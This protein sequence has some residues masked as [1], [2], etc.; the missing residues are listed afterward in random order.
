MKEKDGP[1][2]IQGRYA[3]NRRHEGKR[4]SLEGVAIT[5]WLLGSSP[6]PSGTLKF[7]KIEIPPSTATEFLQVLV[8]GKKVTSDVTTPKYAIKFGRVPSVQHYE[9]EKYFLDNETKG[10][11]QNP[12][13]QNYQN[14][15]VSITLF[16]MGDEVAKIVV[17]QGPVQDLLIVISSWL[18][19]P[20]G[21]L[22]TGLSGHC[23]GGTF[24]LEKYTVPDPNNLPNWVEPIDS[25]FS[26]KHESLGLTNPAGTCPKDRPRLGDDE[27]ACSQW[28]L[29][30]SV[31]EHDGFDMDN[32]EDDVNQC[33]EDCCNNFYDAKNK[34]DRERPYDA[35]DY[36]YLDAPC[37]IP[38]GP[39]WGANDW[40][41]E[42]K[43]MADDAERAKRL[44][45]LA[46]S[47]IEDIAEILKV[48][49]TSEAVAIALQQPLT[50]IATTTT[51]TEV[52]DGP[53]VYQDLG[54]GKC[55]LGSATGPEPKF[56]WADLSASGGD[57]AG[58]C[59]GDRKCFGYS[60]SWTQQCVLYYQ[61]ELVVAAKVDPQNLENTKWREWDNCNCF[62]KRVPPPTTT[63]TTT[64]TVPRMEAMVVITT[65]TTT[66]TMSYMRRVLT[67]GNVIALNGGNSRKWCSDDGWWRVR[68]NRDSIKSWEMYTVFDASQFGAGKIALR[69]GNSGKMCADEFAGVV[70]NRDW[71]LQW[72]A[73]TP[74]NLGQNMIALKGGQ[75][76]M[77]C[78]DEFHR[79][80][81]NRQV[82]STWETFE[83]SLVR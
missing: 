21:G 1:L 51:T 67:H 22:T 41:A 56:V 2:Q 46:T 25:L 37:E 60:K 7:P 12:D 82:R 72:E 28:F 8:D 4:A 42:L 9:G 69:G 76:G 63:T 59:G 31:L 10:V 3:S 33:V 27:M 64:K 6:G 71:I 48:A 50:T 57:C 74:E 55:A 23:G 70:C 47:V 66:T 54:L 45:F 53:F 35:K 80:V 83:L 49:A 79:F 62:V 36:H 18:A 75:K 61:K 78:A 14:N 29:D 81:C 32:F 44:K 11:I 77:Y 34:V 15:G 16:A 39:L 5:G 30:H 52:W 26:W 43:N 40:I 38:F 17:N 73:F 68:C 65:T 13:W 20:D 24:A 58:L 19:D